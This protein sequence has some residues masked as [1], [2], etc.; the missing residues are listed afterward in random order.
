MGLVPD[1]KSENPVKQKFKL[2]LWL[3]EQCL[4]AVCRT[5]RAHTP[6]VLDPID[7]IGPS[8][9]VASCTRGYTRISYNISCSPE[10]GRPIWPIGADLGPIG[11]DAGIHENP[12]LE[13]P[14]FENP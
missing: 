9:H 14:C 2:F 8:W 6:A 11:A 13:N 4:D 5:C 12:I 1:R 3:P 7:Y 10:K